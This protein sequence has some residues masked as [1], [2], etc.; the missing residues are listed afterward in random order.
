MSDSGET[1]FISI[2]GANEKSDAAGR[3]SSRSLPDTL[4]I[5][6]LSDIVIFPGAVVPLLVETGPSLRLVDDLV[7]GDRLFGA[8]LQKNPDVAEPGAEDLHDIGCAARLNKMVKF[9]DG[10]VRVLVEGLWRVR[11]HS[12]SAPAPYL[13]ARFELL[14]NETEDTV[15]LQAMLRNAHQQ[16]EEIA[17]ISSSLSDQVK[18]AA[19]NT[20][21]LYTSDAADE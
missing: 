13:R 21:L 3:V 4:P 16:F 9:P 17:K 8:V 6:G 5:L 15:E 14:R 11:I 1:E 2:L 7:A 18:I 10:T 20:C 12:F 19:L